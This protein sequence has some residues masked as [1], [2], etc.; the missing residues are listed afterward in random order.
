MLLL[1]CLV[2]QW[3]PTLC[4]PVDCSPP[5]SSVHEILQARILEWVATSF[6]RASSW[7]KDQTQVSCIASGFFTIWATR[8]AP[9]PSSFFLNTHFQKLNPL[10]FVFPCSNSFGRRGRKRASFAQ[11]NQMNIFLTNNDSFF[12]LLFCNNFITIHL[13]YHGLYWW[14]SW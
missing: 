6:F 11:M 1:F 8:E 9:Q 4:D 14:L 2:T 3:C 12:D 13:T 10:L 7:P 5:V